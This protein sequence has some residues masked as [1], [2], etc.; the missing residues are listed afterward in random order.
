MTP[1]IHNWRNNGELRHWASFLRQSEYLVIGCFSIASLTPFQISEPCNVKHYVHAKNK[2]M[3][4]FKCDLWFLQQLSM[5]SNNKTHGQQNHKPCEN[6]LSLKRPYESP[7]ECC[8]V[9]RWKHFWLLI[10]MLI[11]YNQ[12]RDK[13][14]SPT[15]SVSYVIVNGITLLY[16]HSE[17]ENRF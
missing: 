11:N 14:A 6:K 15:F 10:G 9:V 7:C 17:R 8:P 5:S 1:L 2:K 16:E 13:R 12:H 3:P 4:H